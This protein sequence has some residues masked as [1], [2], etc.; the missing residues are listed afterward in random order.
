GVL[1]RRRAIGADR[2]VTLP[3]RWHLVLGLAARPLVAVVAPQVLL[4]ALQ[5][6]ALDLAVDDRDVGV[7]VA[8]ERLGGRLQAE[9]IALA[10]RQALGPGVDHAHALHR[11]QAR[12]QRHGPRR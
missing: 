4:R 8:A 11:R 7:E 3:V 12:G 10:A 2:R 6:H 9:H 1:T 5:D